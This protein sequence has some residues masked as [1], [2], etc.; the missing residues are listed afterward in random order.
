MRTRQPDSR[1]S[2]SGWTRIP[3]VPCRAALGNGM[4]MLGSVRPPEEHDGLIKN[5]QEA[6]TNTQAPYIYIEEIDEH[7]L[8]AKEAGA[9]IVYDITDQDYGGRLYTARDPEG[10]LWNFGSTEAPSRLCTAVAKG[11]PVYPPSTSTFCTWLRL[12]RRR[13]NS[14]C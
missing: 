5:P 14:P 11:F 13:V 2:L 10:Y 9:V 6:G 8:R 4:I 12:A 1:A 3:P 7:Y